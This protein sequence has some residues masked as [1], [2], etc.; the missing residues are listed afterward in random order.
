MVQHL[1]P[2]RGGY[3]FENLA[4]HYLCRPNDLS[5]LSPRIFFEKY[6]VVDIPLK[7]QLKRVDVELRFISDTGY[8]KHP[9][10][11]K[12]NGNTF[13]CHQG[14][15]ERDKTSLIKVPQ[16]LWPDTGTFKDN[17]LYCDVRKINNA[18]EQ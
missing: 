11:K 13:L 16:W 7:K 4:L 2:C 12:V 5:S 6:Y 10:L 14:V 9:S 1:K 17:S 15:A 3:Y 8:F 18:M